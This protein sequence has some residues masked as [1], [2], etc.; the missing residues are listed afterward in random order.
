MNFQNRRYIPCILK[1][2]FFFFNLASE[3]FTLALFG[4]ET[5]VPISDT[6][7]KNVFEGVFNLIGLIYPT[8]VQFK[9]VLE[10]IK[11]Y[12]IAANENL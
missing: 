6:A 9:N 8:D 4:N 3:P 7:I 2:N 5:G 11:T 12:P 10:S 1:I